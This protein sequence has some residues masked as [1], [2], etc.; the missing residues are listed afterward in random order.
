MIDVK[1]LLSLRF[2]KSEV[3]EVLEISRK[4]LYNKIAAFPSPEE[5]SKY[6]DDTETQFD[7]VVGRVKQEHPN[8]GEIMIAGHL[9]KQGVRVQRAKLR[10][11]IHRID[12]EGVAERRSV[13]VRRRTYHVTGPNEVWHIDGHH[14]LIKWRLVT[15]GGID[16]YSRLIT[17]LQCSSNNRASTVHAAF[18][19]AV[20]TYGLPKRV[21]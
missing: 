10:K 13:A 17:F 9:L 18:T 6:S 7:V 4:T 14:K 16:G 2:S 12:P 21:E 19:S 15:Q 8:D 20:E 11:S 5:F 1:Y 3:S